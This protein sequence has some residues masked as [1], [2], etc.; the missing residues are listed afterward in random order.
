MFVRAGEFIIFRAEGLM[1]RQR[2]AERPSIRA[3]IFE[4]AQIDPPH[5]SQRKRGEYNHTDDRSDGKN[6]S[7]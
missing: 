6:R 2:R 3:R 1:P 5:S 4:P 7:Q